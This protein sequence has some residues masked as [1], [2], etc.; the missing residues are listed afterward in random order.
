MRLPMKRLFRHWLILLSMMM[1]MLST[2]VASP[3]QATSLDVCPRNRIETQVVATLNKART[4]AGMVRLRVNRLLTRTAQSHADD[5]AANG[6]FDHAGSDGSQV[7]DRADRNGYGWSVIGENLA[8]T[9]GYE[10]SAQR[11][12][13]GWFTSPGHYENMFNPEFREVGVAV[14]CRGSA[15]YYAMVL[16]VR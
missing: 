7:W 4:A 3:S 2:S 14:S 13:D 8:F 16:G 5:M 6:F 15:I 11:A 10:L 1:V 9:D 12:Y